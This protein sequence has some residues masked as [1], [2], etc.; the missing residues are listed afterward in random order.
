MENGKCFAS[1]L[2][3]GDDWRKALDEVAPKVL[4]ELG[5]ES[6]DLALFFI[7]EGFSGLEPAVFS[8]ELMREISSRAIVGCNASGV[9]GGES[10]VEMEPALSV[11]AMRLPGV[12]VHPFELTP[13]ETKDLSQSSQLV[14]LL[15]VYPTDGPKFILLADPM[16]CD[17]SRLMRA[18]NG[19]YPGAPVIGGLASGQVMGQANWLAMNG[20]TMMSGAVGVVLTGSVEIEILV[21]QG[22]RPIGVPYIITEAEENVL[23]RLAGKSAYDILQEV[24]RSLNPEDRELAKHSLFLGLV[25]TEKKSCFERG[26]F[27]IRNIMGYDKNTRALV[28]GSELKTG[29]TVQFQLRDKHTSAEDLRL[30]LEAMRGRKKAGSKG[31]LLVTCCGRGKGLYGA[32]NHDI[33]LIQSLTGPLPVTGF[34][35][36]G[37]IGPV[38]GENFVHGYT[39]SLAVFR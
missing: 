21:A 28:I 6:C 2:Y 37:E 7:S 26:D 8:R 22:C 24:Y 34:F 33:G 25:M 18:F 16:S 32:V 30:M 10:E 5:G 17:V 31:G 20:D 3:R 9:I 27:L 39:S 14:E 1:G 19:A 13:Q 12:T 15:D 38:G 11:L 23:Y 29:Q 36:N 4:R 35:A